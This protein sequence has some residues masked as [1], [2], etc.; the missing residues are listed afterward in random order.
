MRPLSPALL[1]AIA[2][3][4]VVAGLGGASVSG[5]DASAWT[6]LM[7]TPGL[8]RSVALSLWTGGAATA[9]SL[10]IAHAALAVAATSGWG[11]RLRGACLPLLA[12]PHLALA[13]GLVL[14]I[15][16]SGLLM[17][18]V[19]PWATGFERPPD[20]TIVQDA[21]GLALIGGLVLKETP[22]LIVVL[23]GALSQ[24]PASLLM[25]QAQS[26]G[27][28]RFKAWLVAVAP[29]LERQA[30]SGLAAVLVFGMTNV[31]MALPL[32]P[33]SPPTLA[34]RLLEWF[35]GSDLSQRPPAF[36]GAWLLFAV[37]LA[38]LGGAYGAALL[39][40]WIWR[41]AA[42]GGARSP[43]DQWARRATGALI[44]TTLITGVLALIALLLRAS[45]GA[46]RFP[47]LLPSGMS[48][49]TWRRVAPDLAASLATTL[50]LGLATAGFSVIIVLFAAEAL[51]HRPT[52]RR[53]LGALLFIPLFLPQM[54]FLFG[55]QV[56]LVGLRLDGTLLAVCWSHTLFALPYVWASLAEQRASLHPGYSITAKLLGASDLRVFWTVTGPLLLRSILLASAL[57]FSVS[58][59]VYLPTLFA[60]GGRVATLATEAAASMS[61]GNVQ[62]AAANGAAQ[63]LLPLLA[64]AG[65][66]GGSHALFRNRRGVPK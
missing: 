45:G 34:I 11:G 8:W 2:I 23:M 57:A 56:V 15:S 46:W 30:R 25:Q 10:G 20:W 54:A 32:G 37:T 55:W 17:R 9:I 26:L 36:A 58:V 44:L 31:E 5:W 41:R 29:L 38:G 48:F 33:T 49:E 42:F 21:H 62:T 3:V 24:V 60:G 28:G 47:R 50:F 22:F 53:R 65:A 66:V 63:A 13:I 51:H 14:L 12:T 16:P 64:F 7:N 6:A 18:S 35:A 43:H 40:G 39:V 52:A 59:A 1:A 61:A 4:P 19:S 27:Y